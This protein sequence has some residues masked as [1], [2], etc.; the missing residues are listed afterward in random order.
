MDLQSLLNQQLSIIESL[1]LLPSGK[2]R[3]GGRAGGFV[4]VEIESPIGGRRRSVRA[5]CGSDCPPGRVQLVKLDTGEYVAFSPSAARPQEA[6]SVERSSSKKGKLVKKE[7]GEFWPVT[8]AFLYSK[9]KP[10]QE[11]LDGNGAADFDETTW[12]AVRCFASPTGSQ[13]EA[14]AFFENKHLLGD[15]DTPEKALFNQMRADRLVVPPD[16]P[17]ASFAR[18]NA[19]W[20]SGSEDAVI[21]WFYI[22][23]L[24]ETYGL[25]LVHSGLGQIFKVLGTT[26]YPNA[27]NTGEPGPGFCMEMQ[28]SGNT[29]L[30]LYPT[31]Q[32]GQGPLTKYLSTQFPNLGGKIGYHGQIFK[33]RGM[34]DYITYGGGR[35]TYLYRLYWSGIEGVPAYETDPQSPTSVPPD[36]NPGPGTANPWTLE[37]EPWY[38]FGW[39]YPYLRIGC[40][41][42]GG[43]GAVTSAIT[44]SGFGCGDTIDSDKW[45]WNHGVGA[46]ASALDRFAHYTLDDT[47]MFVCWQGHKD[48]ASLA[49]SFFETFRAY[50]GLPGTVHRL[51][52]CNPY[53]CE[54][55]GGG[56]YPPPPPSNVSRFIGQNWGRKAE[57]WLKVCRQNDP[58]LKIKLPFEYCAV[59]EKQTILGGGSFSPGANFESGKTRNTMQTYGLC[60]IGSG[61]FTD[62]F[63]LENPH[64]TL[65]I[66]EEF[67]YVDILYGCERIFEQP[68]T[69]PVRSRLGN[70]GFGG[71][72]SGNNW[73]Y[74]VMG[75][76]DEYVSHISGNRPAN[77]AATMPVLIKD[78]FTSCQSYKIKLPTKD[79]KTLIIV[80]SQ[81]FK[82][83]EVN[84]LTSK[85]PDWECTK[86]FT[87]HDYRTSVERYI[88][89][90]TPPFIESNPDF[91]TLGGLPAL[92]QIVSVNLSNINNFIPRYY[93]PQMQW[94][95]LD[96]VYYQLMGSPRQFNPLTEV[97]PQNVH[98]APGDLHKGSIIF[99]SDRKFGGHWRSEK[100]MVASGF[101]NP[102]ASSNVVYSEYGRTTMF[103]TVIPFTE[104]ILG[105]GLMENNVL[106]K[107]Y[108]VTPSSFPIMGQAPRHFY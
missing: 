95:Q 14:V 5:R 61:G 40:M 107:W 10:N 98:I 2:I 44:G 47:G 72:G 68:L 9:I 13:D 89:V 43:I 74:R 57:M 97:L 104:Q 67:A 46:T 45:F 41:S 58:P 37:D 101:G 105:N 81:K 36:Y 51:K 34:Q 60:Y 78:V 92:N 77:E 24:T 64:A 96:K 88:N 8:S 100:V 86:K 94:T 16:A 50:W 76:A 6:K 27:D 11:L 108:R 56:G 87:I 22:G 73:T 83:G 26:T 31:E 66:D 80:G 71:I 19:A 93:K 99:E 63:G 25:G 28:R 30:A 18:D 21:I 65:A 7:D 84:T 23:D 4:D 54:L 62:T 85:N 75:R 55:P 1:D 102:T 69:L 42:G 53:G 35:R 3:F 103:P 32:M 70:Q 29:S 91:S 48:N 106:I 12:D 20:G 17:S 38:R 15:Y 82:R 59:L 52:S 39:D 90:T 79:D 33:W 49:Q